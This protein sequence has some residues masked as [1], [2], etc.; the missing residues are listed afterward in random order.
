M[1]CV[2]R[3]RAW[4]LNR[5]GCS[6]RSNFSASGDRKPL[7]SIRYLARNVSPS[8]AVTLTPSSSTSTSFARQFCRVVAP[9]LA[10]TLKKYWSVSCR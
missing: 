7:A 9:Y 6:R 10:A 3:V 2:N 1:K 8:A 5:G 4:C